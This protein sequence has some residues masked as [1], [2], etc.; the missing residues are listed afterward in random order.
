MVRMGAVW[1]RTAEF[2]TDNLGAIL[3]VALLAFFAPFS[4][5]GSFQQASANATESLK[6]VFQFASLAVGV[7]ALWGALALAAMVFGEDSRRAGA[8]AGR[9][10]LPA[11]FVQVMLAIGIT[12]LFL[13][14]MIVGIAHGVDVITLDWAGLL[15]L[16]PQVWSVANLNALVVL[17]LM[18]W[19]STR[20]LLTTPV[21]LAEDRSFGAILRSWQ[22]TRGM[23]LQILGVILL[24]CIVAVV[25]ELATRFVFGSIFQLIAGSAT[26]LSLS[27]VLTSITVAA[28]RA[29]L[30]VVSALFTANLLLALAP[31]APA[32]NA[33]KA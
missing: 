8:R 15:S 14:T 24:F 23:T 11:L 12:L 3:P 5:Y 33:S 10:L 16:P 27:A 32:G 26:G 19:L 13:P 20:L 7:L 17:P 25:A 1:D 21:V 28:V 6:L 4:I 30:A 2:L 9:R 29:I 31:P 18:L 22:L